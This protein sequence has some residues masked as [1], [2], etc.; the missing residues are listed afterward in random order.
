MDSPFRL[1]DWIV[2]PQRDCIERD[3]DSVR[4]KPKAMAV[5]ACLARAG[6]EVVTRNELFERVWPGGVV[7]DATLTQ[8][9]VELRQALQDSA[10]DP[11]FI[12]TVPKVGFRLIPPVLHLSPD[13]SIPEPA[14]AESSASADSTAVP[15]RRPLKWAIAVTA[16]VVLLL[17]FL[18]GFWDR[19]PPR[20]GADVKSLAVLPFQDLSPDK[21]HGIAEQ[22]Y[23]Q[24]TD[25]AETGDRHQHLFTD[26]GAEQKPIP[27]HVFTPFDGTTSNWTSF[28]HSCCFSVAG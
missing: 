25:H 14:E 16:L 24:K 15:S 10:R 9:V 12:E 8:C 3:G 2:R 1:G 7:S 21:S 20:A 19:S 6:G 4:L 18:A 28:N 17:S 26:G 27:F 5:L 22:V 23:G 13:E 11:K